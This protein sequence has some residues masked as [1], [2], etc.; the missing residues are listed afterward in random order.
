MWCR[1][2][3]CP[4]RT[5]WAPHICRGHITHQMWS[6]TSDAGNLHV[7]FDEGD[8]ETGI[9]VMGPQKAPNRSYEAANRNSFIEPVR[10][11]VCEA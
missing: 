8:V 10:N 6:T 11:F 9:P 2:Q 5:R 3:P 7:R 4:L 1:A